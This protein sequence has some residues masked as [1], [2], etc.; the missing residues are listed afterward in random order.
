VGGGG[1]ACPYLQMQD[2]QEQISPF[3]LADMHCEP[4]GVGLLRQCQ[5]PDG[6]GLVPFREDTLFIR[7]SW[8][9]GTG[10][11]LYEG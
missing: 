8:L 3:M 4:K 1:G 6:R 7:P 5:M 11:H 2:G 9:G 10:G